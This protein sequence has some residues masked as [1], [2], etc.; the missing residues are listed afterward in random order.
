MYQK[1]S[2][3]E[4]SLVLIKHPERHDCVLN[5]LIE[6]HDDQVLLHLGFFKMLLPLL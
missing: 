4:L 6:S 3:D 5:V 2:K 1:P